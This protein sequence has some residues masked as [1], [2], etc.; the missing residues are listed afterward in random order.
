MQ[1][2]GGPYLPGGGLLEVRRG[3]AKRCGSCCSLLFISDSSGETAGFRATGVTVLCP[4]KDGPSRSSEWLRQVRPSLGPPFGR[5]RAG[6]AI[7]T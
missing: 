5:Q 3:A 4:S 6:R 7:R 2:Q 1:D